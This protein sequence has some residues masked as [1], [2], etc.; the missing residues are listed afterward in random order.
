M[1]NDVRWQYNAT[2]SDRINRLYGIKPSKVTIQLDQINWDASLRNQNRQPDPRGGQVHINAEHVANIAQGMWDGAL[3]D[4]PVVRTNGRGTY[5]LDGNHRLRAALDLGET[6]VSAWAADELTDENADQY[7]QFANMHHGLSNSPAHKQ[8]VIESAI[9]AGETLERVAMLASVK[10]ATIKGHVAKGRAERKVERA[11]GA[12]KVKSLSLKQAAAVNRL[13][14]EEVAAI[15]PVLNLVQAGQLDEWTKRIA[16]E[17]PKNREAMAIQV[18]GEMLQSV[19]AGK[20][21]TAKP[22]AEARRGVS[23]LRTHLRK[24]MDQ[25]TKEQANKLYDDLH[26]VYVIAADMRRG[27]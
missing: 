18:R 16:A 7:A 6:E 2:D 26:A 21:T 1:G 23:L 10:V 15:G 3:I 22:L 27:E 4:A 5:V 25:A 8:H 11:L 12:D 9:A 20:K 24:A 17:K 19:A 14:D 13:E